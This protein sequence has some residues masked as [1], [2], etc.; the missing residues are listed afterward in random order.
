SVEIIRSCGDTL[1][2]LVND[3]LDFSKIESRRIDLEQRPFTLRQPID[4]AMMLV[5][6][7]CSRKGLPVRLTIDDDVPG[8]VIGDVT[9]VRQ[10]LVN[11]LGNAVKFTSAGLIGVSV[12]AESMEDP[13]TLRIHF[14][15]SDTGIGIAPDALARLF[16]PF[17]QADASTTR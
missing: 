10:V 15:V 11:L 13:E 5:S 14:A 7:A 3:V 8:V 9:R 4:D 12:S 17:T 1:L 2:A 16:E 6:D